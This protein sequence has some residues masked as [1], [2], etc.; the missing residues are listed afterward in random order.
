MG[1]DDI[2]IGRWLAAIAVLVAM[3]AGW[4][5]YRFLHFLW[6]WIVSRK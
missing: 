2:L 1:Y 3:G 6:F 4:G 5:I